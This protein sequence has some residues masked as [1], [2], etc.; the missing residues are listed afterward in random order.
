MI[1]SVLYLVNSQM[2]TLSIITWLLVIL[3]FPILGTLFL[4]YTKQDWGYRELKSLIK[5]STQAIKPYFQ[6]DQRILYKLKES[7]ARTYNLAQY[8]HRSGGFP[9]YKN[10]KVTYFPNGQSKFKEMKKQLLKA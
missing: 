6:Y 8:L 3:P 10:T 4:I 5:K 2:D 9:V 1:G 7:H